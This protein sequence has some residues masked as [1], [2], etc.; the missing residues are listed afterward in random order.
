MYHFFVKK[1]LSI[2]IIQSVYIIL[3][4]KVYV[5]IENH[6]QVNR[7]FSVD[8]ASGGC[9]YPI[10][11]QAKAALSQINPVSRYQSIEISIFRCNN[12]SA[13]SAPCNSASDWKFR[14]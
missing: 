8:I 3:L 12:R 4:Y 1:Y 10:N 14:E 9:Q 2:L 13:A 7:V 11:A 6:S 5:I